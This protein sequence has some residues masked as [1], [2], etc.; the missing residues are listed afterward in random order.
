MT[1]PAAVSGGLL[2]MA[3]VGVIARLFPDLGRWR[4]SRHVVVADS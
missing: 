1:T 4:L 2:C 3:G